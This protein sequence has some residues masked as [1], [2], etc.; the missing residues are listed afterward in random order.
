LY[1]LSDCGAHALDVV[2]VHGRKERQR[3]GA[4][5]N[6]LGVREFAFAVSL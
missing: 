1:Y 6:A 3:D 4:L 2:I 5:A